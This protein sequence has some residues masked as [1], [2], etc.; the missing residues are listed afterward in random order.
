M[1]IIGKCVIAMSKYYWDEYK[2]YLINKKDLVDS[3]KFY[4]SGCKIEKVNTDLMISE[5]LES[6]KGKMIFSDISISQSKFN[7]N[8][9]NILKDL[10]DQINGYVK[11]VNIVNVMVVI[12]CNNQIDKI[13]PGI[14][15][16]NID[17][18]ELIKYKEI[19]NCIGENYDFEISLFI[20]IES[21]V[22]SNGRRGLLEGAIQIGEI[23]NLINSVL[24]RKGFAYR[25]I[26]VNENAYTYDLS[27]NL[28]KQL[29]LKVIGVSRNDIFR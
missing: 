20:D 14:Y 3:V 13:E 23:L 15:T 6:R 27:I 1:H 10:V 18:N 16:I 25:N 24:D 5:W 28:T 9:S 2:N 17:Q 12:K 29:L 4:Q 11:R 19:E 8:D 21:A 26:D 7:D 22:L